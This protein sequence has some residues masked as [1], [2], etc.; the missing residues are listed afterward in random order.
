VSSLIF[1]GFACIKFESFG[2]Y[3]HVIASDAENARAKDGAN[4]PHRAEY[5]VTILEKEPL[6]AAPPAA[7]A[8]DRKQNVRIELKVS[9][10][11]I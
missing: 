7:L 11:N 2:T 6:L 3:G 10:E 4:A 9:D 8:L 1:R 5:A